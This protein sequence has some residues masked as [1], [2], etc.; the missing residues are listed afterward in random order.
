MLNPAD[1][2]LSFVTDRE[3]DTPR[4]SIRSSSVKHIAVFRTP[5]GDHLVCYDGNKLKI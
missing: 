3:N 2:S 5:R 1:K 4:M